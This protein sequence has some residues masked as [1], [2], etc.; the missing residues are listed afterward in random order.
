MSVRSRTVECAFLPISAV[1]PPLVAPLPVAPLP[2][3]PLPGSSM[4]VP[5][6]ASEAA[7]RVLLASERMTPVAVARD[8]FA[9]L[10]SRAPC[11]PQETEVAG[12]SPSARA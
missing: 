6:G 7:A 3:V 2:V 4:V 11:Q 9:S 8:S 1:T 12:R 5:S 10:R